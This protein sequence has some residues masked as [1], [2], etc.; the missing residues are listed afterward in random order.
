MSILTLQSHCFSSLQNSVFSLKLSPISVQTA[1][2]SLFQLMSLFWGE[3]ENIDTRALYS[4]I[5]VLLSL[6]FAWLTGTR[7]CLLFYF[8][9]FL[10]V[11]NDLSSI[12]VFPVD[13]PLPSPAWHAACRPTHLWEWNHHCPLPEWK[14][15]L[16]SEISFGWMHVE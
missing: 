11:F 5:A 14:Q 7:V 6:H 15:I 10:R 12:S 16:I 13:C 9:R 4:F 8:W 1:V 2:Y 3:G